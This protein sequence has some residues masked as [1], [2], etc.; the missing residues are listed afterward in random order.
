MERIRVAFARGRV[1][2][3]EADI[4]GYFGSIDQQQLLALVADRVSDRRVLTLLRLWLQAGAMDDGV[5]RET[6]TGTP[7]GGVISLDAARVI[8]AELGLRL[9]PET[10]RIVDLRRAG[11]ALT[12]SAAAFMRVC[13]A[14]CW[15][16]ASAATICIAGPLR[17]R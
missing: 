5:V 12:S 14:G 16:A 2:V 8:L 15:S 10:T 17:A 11:K 9:H 3:A 13:R 6:V 1:W 7:Q 4:R